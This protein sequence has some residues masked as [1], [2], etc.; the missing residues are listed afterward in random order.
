[1]ERIKINQLKEKVGKKVLIKGFVHE[2][3]DQSKVKFVLI[4]DNSGIIQTVTTPD[5]KNIFSKI[6]KIPKESVVSIE[7]EVKKSEKAPDGI[8]I[9]VD[10]YEVLSEAEQPLPIDM[11]DFSKTNIDKRLDWRCLSLRTKKSRAIFKIQAK[12]I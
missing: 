1:M 8:E 2:L 6:I 5:K 11:S 10:K 7:G 9:H 12:I 3:R 4:R